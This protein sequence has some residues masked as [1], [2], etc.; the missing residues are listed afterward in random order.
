MIFFPQRPCTAAMNMFGCASL[1]LA[2]FFVA[3]TIL[4]SDLGFFQLNAQTIRHHKFLYP[5]RK[6]CINARANSRMSRNKATYARNTQTRGARK[7]ATKLEKRSEGMAARSP[8]R[9]ETRR[10]E[11]RSETTGQARKKLQ[12]RI[13][14][15]RS[16][17]SDTTR[18]HATCYSIQRPRCH[19]GKGTCGQR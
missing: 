5:G 17:P 10:K 7:H 14:A 9:K 4:G 15:G 18:A 1:A 13:N 3:N 8:R 6:Q 11:H 16:V 2:A 19:E 12:R